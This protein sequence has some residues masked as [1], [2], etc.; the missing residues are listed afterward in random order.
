MIVGGLAAVAVII[1]GLAAAVVAARGTQ[2]SRPPSPPRT[3]SIKCS[4]PALGGTLPTLVYL[5]SGYPD[6][7][8]HYPVIYFLHGLP[9]GPTAYT[10]NAF[11]AQAVAGTG[12]SA[13][14]VAPQG[15]RDVDSDDEYLDLAGNRN[16]PEAISHDLPTCIDRRLRTIASRRGRALIGL[17]AGGYGAFNIGLR[18]LDRFSAV[19]SWSGYFAATD[20]SGRK[21]LD[22]GSPEANAEA[23]V[24]TGA[25]L[26]ATTDRLPTLIAFYVGNQ[27]DRFLD[28]NQAFHQALKR[29]GVRHLFRVYGGGHSGVLWHTQ[30]PH[31]LEMALARLDRAQ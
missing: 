31:W 10:S 27:D 26:K 14:V 4:A 17:S 23:Q 28:V 5:P 13:I 1:A 19:E 7:S 3:L 22:L 20:P 21:V 11:V 30:A 25:G 2:P 15:A 9:A 8:E 29:S 16:W 24:P 12:K 6:G 18:H